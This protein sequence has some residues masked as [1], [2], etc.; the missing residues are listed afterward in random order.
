MA[1]GAALRPLPR[2]GRHLGHDDR[3]PAS[4]GRRTPQRVA[5]ASGRPHRAGGGQPR[6]AGRQRDPR[7]GA[8]RGPR[9]PGHPHRPPAGVGAGRFL[10]GLHVRGGA[11]PPRQAAPYDQDPDEGRPDPPPRLPG[12]PAMSSDLH[13]LSGAY[14]LDALS[15]EERARFATHLQECSACREEVRELQE[16]ASRM[17]AA[18]PI[19][20][21]QALKARVLAAADRQPQ[22]PPKVTSL[23]RARKH[24]RRAWI[25]GAAA[26]VVLLLAGAVTV[27]RLQQQDEPPVATP[28]VAQVFEAPDAH[29]ATVRTANGGR[30]RVATSAARDQMAVATE[31][32]PRLSHRSYQLWAIRDGKATSV[33]VVDDVGVGE[34]LRLPAPGTT[35][36]ITVEPP[37]GSRQPTQEPIVAMD[38]GA[39]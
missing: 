28:S 34:V 8:G 14:A 1:Q 10:Q 29:T 26:A 11:G 19:A 33:G 24:G 39:V 16:A 21:P 7:R 27:L 15:P 31:G 30:L 17:G 3:A 37:G 13:T 6:R 23:E 4:G 20:P 25:A 5:Q 38:P 2:Q 22:L 18:E 9:V 32:L 36:A 12:G 35:V